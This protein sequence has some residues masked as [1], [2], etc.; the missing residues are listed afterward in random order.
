[1]Q[2]LHQNFKEGPVLVKYQT[3]LSKAV[4]ADSQYWHFGQ[5]PSLLLYNLM[6]F[7][8]LFKVNYILSMA[9]W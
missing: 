4:S 1:M 6:L 7:I 3:V 5:G 9:F 8:V 2:K